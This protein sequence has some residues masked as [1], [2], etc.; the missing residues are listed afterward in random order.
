MC[1]IFFEKCRSAYL[2]YDISYLLQAFL[3]TSENVFASIPKAPWFSCL[4][5]F[6]A[7]GALMLS[8]APDNKE[9]N[10]EQNDTRAVGGTGGITSDSPHMHH[11]T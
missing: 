2:R 8:P 11:I 3:G 10:L 1:Q 5:N 4:V 7:G 9:R 6:T